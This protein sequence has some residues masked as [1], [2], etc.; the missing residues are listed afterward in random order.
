MWQS[1]A[2]VLLLAASSKVIRF[3]TFVRYTISTGLFHE[4]V[5]I[6][7]C[8]AL[9]ALEFW[10]G[11]LLCTKTGRRLGALA[12][13]GV[14]S[15]FSVIHV[16]AVATGEI[17]ACRCLAVRLVNNDAASHALMALL[18]S[19]LLYVSIVQYRRSIRCERARL[20]PQPL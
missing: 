15:A 5:A 4:R 2:T 14:F 10:V 17:E 1:L 19:A 11:L 9:I 18:S 7:A 20:L 6:Y 8:M 16:F 12:V 3:E 13:A